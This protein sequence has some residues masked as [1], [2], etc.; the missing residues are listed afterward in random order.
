MWATS[1]EVSSAPM[2]E[3]RRRLTSDESEMGNA[4][5]GLGRGGRTVVGRPV[6]ESPGLRSRV[7]RRCPKTPLWEASDEAGTRADLLSRLAGGLARGDLAHGSSSVD[8]SL[9]GR[10]RA[11]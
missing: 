2:R 10:D 8:F 11:L 3:R 7:N 6:S 5:F 9:K 1:W 4:V